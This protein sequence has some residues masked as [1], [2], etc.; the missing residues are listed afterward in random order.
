MSDLMERLR[1]AQ[2][3]WDVLEDEENRDLVKEAADEIERLQGL[4][5]GM[6]NA[7]P[8]VVQYRRKDDGIKWVD[9]AAYDSLTIAE[10]Y[11]DKCSCHN[12]PWEYR[13]IERQQ[14]S[15]A[16]LDKE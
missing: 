12:M 14:I 13:V 16:K 6:T 11:R 10:N 2:E 15:K 4:V 5:E 8:F 7:L 1:E 9:M 3:D